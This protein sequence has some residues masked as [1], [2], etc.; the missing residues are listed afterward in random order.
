MLA[1]PICWSFPWRPNDGSSLITF[2]A[3]YIQPEI[4]LGRL[5]NSF[6]THVVRDTDSCREKRGLPDPCISRGVGN[7]PHFGEGGG[8]GASLPVLVCAQNP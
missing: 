8:G 3:V 7:Y 5:A 4:V 1:Y 2:N 6:S